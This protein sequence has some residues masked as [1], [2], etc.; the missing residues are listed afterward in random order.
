M[1]FPIICIL[2][3]RGAGKTLLMTALA[4]DSFITE[5]KNIFAN[6][7]LKGFHYRSIKVSELG[8]FPDWLTDGIILIDEMQVGGDAYNFLHKNVKGMTDFITQIRKRRLTFIYT[9]QRFRTVTKRLRDQT[10][11]IYE[12][13]E[14]LTKGDVIL[15]IHDLHKPDDLS[16][17]SKHELSLQ[18]YFKN[19]DTNEIIRDV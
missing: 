9:T 3:N 7:T 11:F 18:A 13:E 6:Y 8:K 5:K 16:F 19:Y 15:E 2:G 10:D 4:K 1:E 12:C 14:G 17:V